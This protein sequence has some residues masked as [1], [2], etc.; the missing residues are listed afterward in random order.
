MSLIGSIGSLPLHKVKLR[1]MFL[2]FNWQYP[3]TTSVSESISHPELRLPGLPFLCIG[4]HTSPS[5]GMRLSLSTTDH[6]LPCIITSE[7]LTQPE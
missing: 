4:M 3:S 7:A 2:S 5:N 1:H 6:A